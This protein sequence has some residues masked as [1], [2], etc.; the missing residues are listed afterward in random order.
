MTDLGKRERKS[1]R[2][3]DRNE[4]E[5]V[6]RGQQWPQAISALNHG[7]ARMSKEIEGI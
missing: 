5:P 2:D 4:M 6:T 1:R 3:S 7:W